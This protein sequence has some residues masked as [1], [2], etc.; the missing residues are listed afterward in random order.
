MNLRHKL[1]SLNPKEAANATYSLL[2]AH[3]QKPIEIQVFTPMILSYLLAKHYNMSLGDL[4]GYVQNYLNDEEH[5]H[6]FEAVEEYL[7]NEVPL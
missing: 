3:Q 4:W 6:Q 1:G 2:T 7:K 5:Q